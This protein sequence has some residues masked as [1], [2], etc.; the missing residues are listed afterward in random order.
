MDNVAHKNAESVPCEQSVAPQAEAGIG[1][2]LLL[3]DD[4]ELLHEFVGAV[5]E[6]NGHEVVSLRDPT[7]TLEILDSGRIDLVLL[8]VNMP[9]MDGFTVLEAIRTAYP[10]ATLPVI[11]L[12]GA[13]GS[14]DV[15]R[16]FRLGAN[17]YATKSPE[18]DVLLQRVRV[19]LGLSRCA[20]LRVGPYRLV[21]KVGAGSMGIVH[22]AR[23]LDDDARVALKILPRSLAVDEAY[24]R[25]FL[26]EASLASRVEHRNVVRVLGTGRFGES[27]YIVMELIEG[28]DLQAALEGR[29]L[30][31]ALAIEL[32]REVAEG[33]RA[34]NEAG[35]IHR[36][37]KPQNIILSTSGEVKIT[38][39]GIA[40][41]EVGSRHTAPG[42][43]VG[44]PA[45][46]APEQ[47]AGLTDYRS[48]IYSIGATLY[49]LVT[50]CSPYPQGSVADLCQAKARR[51]AD[52]RKLGLA[53]PRFVVRLIEKMMAPKIRNRFQSYEELHE[54]LDKAARRLP[55]PRDELRR[56]VAARA[57]VP[58]SSREGSV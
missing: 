46:A 24:V 47:L 9:D 43:S 5:L 51:A 13:D 53:L 55:E 8:D 33:C 45:Y 39:F 49:Y 34:L 17:D 22:E 42:M 2:R 40:H 36:D 54:A 18:L 19:H 11:M 23:R 26:R 20:S 32:V 1:G 4:D 37:V 7:R 25:R 14:E 41:D 48:D 21:R 27:Y 50:G 52:P 12:T 38:D 15:I 16:A 29:P 10:R 56:F 35:I 58:M 6:E 3:V 44:S 28:T 30:D 31:P 57:S